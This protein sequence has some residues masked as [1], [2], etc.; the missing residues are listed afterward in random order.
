MHYHSE[1][2][3]NVKPSTK[4]LSVAYSVSLGVLAISSGDQQILFRQ[5]DSS[6]RTFQELKLKV[7]TQHEIKQFAFLSEDSECLLV[8][9]R[10]S[11]LLIYRIDE[12]LRQISVEQFF[13]ISKV[14][15]SGI[16]F[17]DFWL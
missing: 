11:S 10:N 1:I 13:S 9:C 17:D 5:Y 3:K 14:L 6:K 4:T 8:L 16:T 12:S 15:L 2:F 7:L